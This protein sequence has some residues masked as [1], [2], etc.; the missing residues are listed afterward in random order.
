MAGY[1]ANFYDSAA[2][3]LGRTSAAVVSAEVLTYLTPSSVVDLGC[4]NGAWVWAF[5]QRGIEDYLGVDGPWVNT[6]WLDIPAAKFR[7]DDLAVGASIDR[8]FDLAISVEVGEHLP[9]ASAKGFVATLTRAAPVV[10]FS[11]AIPYQGGTGHVNEQWPSYWAEKFAAHGYVP[12]DVLR[13]KLWDRED[14]AYYYRQNLTFYVRESAL[15]D[16]PALQ[17]GYEE[18]GGTLPDLIHP[19]VWTRRSLQPVNVPRI[20]GRERAERLRDVVNN[21]RRRFARHGG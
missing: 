10:L 18:T 4:G 15:G 11:A 19:E 7:H 21:Q 6:D 17:Q 5:A 12:V 16:Y 2:T 14:V 13:R 3:D 9:A 1:D 20:V 8:T